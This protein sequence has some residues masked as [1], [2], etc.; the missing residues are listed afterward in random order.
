MSWA[1]TRPV[2]QATELC[3]RITDKYGIY[4]KKEHLRVELSLLSSQEGIEE[5]LEMSLSSIKW[6]MVPLS[7][8]ECRIGRRQKSDLFSHHRCQE[9]YGLERF[10]FNRPQYELFDI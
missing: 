5:V 7:Q 8:P 4:W 1:E 3:D 2:S 9:C 6:S 10:F